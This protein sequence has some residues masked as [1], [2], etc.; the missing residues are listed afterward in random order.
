MRKEDGLTPAER[1]F[2][3][4]L[5]GLQPAG[6]SIDRDALMYQAGYAA[7]SRRSWPWQGLAALLAVGLAASLA[8]QGLG[9]SGAAAQEPRYASEADR[10]R[11]VL[12]VTDPKSEEEMTQAKYFLLREEVLEKG[13]AAL[14]EPAARKSNQEPRLTLEEL[15]GEPRGVVRPTRGPTI[16]DR[17]LLGDPL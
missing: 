17:I 4:V 15:L 3:E 7:A 11:A 14:P 13:L 5:A 8:V 10:V 1:E 9:R 16:V 12:A 2:E 6:T